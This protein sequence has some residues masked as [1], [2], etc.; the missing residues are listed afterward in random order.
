MPE[1]FVVN[2]DG[3]QS[4]SVP[5]VALAERLEGAFKSAAAQLSADGSRA[6]GNDKPGA[7]FASG[8]VPAA[9]DI[10][11]AGSGIGQVLGTSAQNL[12][13]V[14]KV[15]QNANEAAIQDTTRLSGR[16]GGSSGRGGSGGGRGGR[17]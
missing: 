13:A 11:K 16:L 5:L 9:Q 7:Q 12:R 1:K 8:Y 14:A 17:P 4:A 15:F 10:I 6:W 2:P 3:L